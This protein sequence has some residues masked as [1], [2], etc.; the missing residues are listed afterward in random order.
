MGSRVRPKIL[1][2]VG[3]LDEIRRIS[4]P[5][6]FIRECGKIE[7]L[8]EWKNIHPIPK[9]LLSNFDETSFDIQSISQNPYNYT[10]KLFKLNFKIFYKI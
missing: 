7:I 2:K 9:L 6:W 8:M 1:T 5:N 3:I 10:R 4:S